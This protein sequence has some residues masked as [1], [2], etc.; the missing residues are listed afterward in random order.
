MSSPA[1]PFSILSRNQKPPGF[2][3][4]E[5]KPK[6]FHHRRGQA[7]ANVEEDDDS[8]DDNI[9]PQSV[10][11]M[12]VDNNDRISVPES[13]Y[14]TNKIE[15]E[16]LKERLKKRRQIQRTVIV[17]ENRP[18]EEE[19]SKPRENRMMIEENSE[20][21]EEEED[22]AMNAR[23]RR[24]LLKEKL[25]EQEQINEEVNEEVDEDAMEEEIE[26]IEGEEETTGGIAL[27]KPVFVSKKERDTNDKRIVKNF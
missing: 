24:A 12:T 15:D 4:P 10:T 11:H 27:L 7:P 21:K 2:K 3:K 20:T 26:D 8:D 17:E 9:Y 16:E 13:N 25:L 23:R 1:D 5:A 19:Q 22:E 6:V 18:N 14:T